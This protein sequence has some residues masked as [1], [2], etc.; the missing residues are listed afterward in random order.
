MPACPASAGFTT[1][2]DAACLPHSVVFKSATEIEISPPT[3]GKTDD[4]DSGWL[5]GWR[6]RVNI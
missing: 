4:A 2:D 6:P 3:V 1:V 5:D